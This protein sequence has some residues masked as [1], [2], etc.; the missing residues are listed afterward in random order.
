M[1]NLTD[2]GKAQG[3]KSTKAHLF[4]KPLAITI[5]D[6]TLVKK[7]SIVQIETRIATIATDEI[8]C[9]V[10]DDDLV[11]A[12]TKA[13]LIAKVLNVHNELLRFAT[14]YH[15]NLEYRKENYSQTDLMD[16]A[17]LKALLKQAEQK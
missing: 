6:N 7:P 11:K 4:G 2:Q 15:D 17:E 3:A 14:K 8:I 13:N 5:F 12:T 16:L 10:K 1:K 9:T